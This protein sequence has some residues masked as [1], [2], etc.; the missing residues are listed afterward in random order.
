MQI[1]QWY[2]LALERQMT[3]THHELIGA[4]TALQE[5]LTSILMLKR[6]QNLRK[7][8]EKQLAEYEHYKA[9][10]TKMLDE[11]G[12]SLLALCK[13]GKMIQSINTKT[14]GITENKNE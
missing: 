9:R 2:L 12:S 1:Q 11:M 14:F 10:R 7:L 4:K 13:R 5:A 3:D 8:K 6:T